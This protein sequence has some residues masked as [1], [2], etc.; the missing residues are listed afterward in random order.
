MEQQ[1]QN[2]TYRKMSFIY[3]A[4]EDGWTV[5]KKNDIYIFKKKHEDKREIFEERY[6]ENFVKKHMDKKIN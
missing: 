2:L 1:T 6:L 5:K 3:N 4:L